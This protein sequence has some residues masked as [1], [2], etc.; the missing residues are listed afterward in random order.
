VETLGAKSE[1]DP[2]QR[3]VEDEDDRYR[4]GEEF[5]PV[6]SKR[7]QGKQEHKDEDH[8]RSDHHRPIGFAVQAALKREQ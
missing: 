3:D 6:F 5:E 8:R 4:P 7:G 1:T 2:N